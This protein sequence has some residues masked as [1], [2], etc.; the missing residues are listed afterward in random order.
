M[1]TSSSFDLGTLYEALAA[2]PRRTAE[3]QDTYDT[4][5]RRVEQMKH[6]FATTTGVPSQRSGTDFYAVWAGRSFGIF[7]DW[8]MC[9]A[10]V[11]GYP[12]N[13]YQKFSTWATAVEAV[14]E[15][16]WAKE[17]RQGPQSTP[18]VVP[19]LPATPTRRRATAS[20]PSP[21]PS[22]PSS[23]SHS[24][25]LSP[26]RPATTPTRAMPTPTHIGGVVPPE[27][28]VVWGP[29]NIS[30]F[31]ER[32]DAEQSAF[33]LEE[34]GELRQ[35]VVSNTRTDALAALMSAATETRAQ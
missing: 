20:S 33:K 31:V 11:I 22:T 25:M 5:K 4:L 9:S 24:R 17:K 26:R 18:V 13:G 14:T 32:H 15:H 27:Y 10:S 30:F 19:A 1:M 6:G 2:P 29:R 12:H 34:H 21:S 7:A 28:F 3:E 35:F 23:L 16:L 8:A